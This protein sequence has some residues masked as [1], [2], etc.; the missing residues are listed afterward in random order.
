M[1]TFQQEA[2]YPP[3]FSE[4]PHQ[5]F[6]DTPTLYLPIA[7]KVYVTHEMSSLHPNYCFISL[8]FERQ[9]K[10]KQSFCDSISMF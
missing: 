3:V 10:R 7:Q 2:V 8:L 9:V 4:K 5:S 1:I 6:S